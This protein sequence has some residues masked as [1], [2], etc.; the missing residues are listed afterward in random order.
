M[1]IV[2]PPPSE[3]DRD[4]PE[5]ATRSRVARLQQA[6]EHAA[7]VLPAQPPIRLFVHHNTLHAYEH[8]PF[9]DA[10]TLA[11]ERFGAQPYPTEAEFAD[12]Y[13]SGRIRPEDID[14]VVAAAGVPDEPIFEGGP[15]R[16]TFASVRLRHIFEIPKGAALDWLLAETDALRVCHRSLDDEQRKRLCRR[17]T[18]ST[19]R[20]SETDV[21]PRMLA[22]LWALLVT[23]APVRHPGVAGPRPRD[24]V[25]AR[26]GVDID[27][28]VNPLLV[29]VSAAFV[30]Q[31][32]SYWSMPSR[33]AGLYEAFRRLY[34][35]PWGP[36]TPWMAELSA[37]LRL[38]ARRDWKAR[39]VLLALLDELGCVE[40]QWQPLLEAT[41]LS[42]PGFAAMIRQLELRPDRAPVQ[43][44]PATL[45]DFLAVRLTLEVV[46]ANDALRTHARDD[47]DE[48]SPLYDRPSSSLELVYEAFVCAQL[49]G[50]V[51]ADLAAEGAPE[52][53]VR[54][55]AGFGSVERRRL[56]HR[57]Y[58]RRH[59][60]G[61]LDG[62]LNHTRLGTRPPKRPRL[63]ALFCIDDREESFRRHLEELTPEIETF[64]YA[65][66]FG[67]PMAYRGLEDVKPTPLCPVPITP[68]HLVTEI[69]REVRKA[70][71][72]GKRRRIAGAWQ[73]SLHVGSTTAVRGGVISALVGLFS[74]VPLI[75][76]CLFPRTA[77]HLGHQ[78]HRRIIGHTHTRLVV[79]RSEAQSEGP[80]GLVLG[81]TVTEMAD[82]VAGVLNTIGAGDRLAPLVL[83]IGHGSSSLNNPHE[84][85][86]DCG[87]CGGGRGGPNARAFAVMANHPEV[88]T[89]LKTAHG[90]AIPDSTWFV[91][92][93]HNTC[94][95]AVLLYDTDL[96][97]EALRGDLDEVRDDLEIARRLDAQ[98]R[99]RRFD[100]APTTPNLERALA[101][102]EAHAADLGQP[103]PEYGHA[104][105]A[106]CIVGRRFRTRG[107]FLDRRA[108]LVSYDPRRDSQ[109]ELLGPLLQSVVPVCAGINLEYYFSYVD[110]HRYGSG[111]K[112]PH[113]ITGLIGVMD[114]HA[115]DLRTGLPWQMAEIHEPVRLLTI[116]EAE[117]DV[118][119]SVLDS[120]PSVAK[121]VHNGWIQLVVWSPSSDQMRVFDR[122]EW[123]LYEQESL[124][125]PSV[126]RSADHYFGRGGHLDCCRIEA[127]LGLEDPR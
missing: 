59:R 112:L 84:A 89:Q 9:D 125:L 26:T 98:E 18:E 16:R 56:L 90:L 38:Q 80:D 21:A 20:G 7:E 31:G 48:V 60:I 105:N 32:V 27:E 82:I 53:W 6:V 74:V 115:S 111:T 100:D 122:G 13:G 41:L 1:T 97:P 14:A 39:D 62:I 25:L 88:R 77:E 63:Q 107:L 69:P 33:E 35:Q 120:C 51:S 50:L 96:V 36:P 116:V 79:A 47:S 102:A 54:A 127:A 71:A 118:V 108:F 67:I 104:T 43:A 40:D 126:H 12:H 78:A 3:P 70:T 75:L 81:F 86:H 94:D 99:C 2:S 8:L 87:A 44:P 15:T 110:N 95:D 85:A 114:G 68:K 24:A 106:V 45:L 119:S 22:E 28:R 72:V 55:V 103:R 57:A 11:A 49:L 124:A 42:L 17:W 5:V 117:L 4:I 83:V 64:G 123:V 92:G 121:L 37:R 52:A 66:F 109:G 113:N 101:C 46:A 65:G 61:V 58:E 10:V 19:A 73:H 93:Y 91:G 34:A 30:D 29:R 23:H 76:R